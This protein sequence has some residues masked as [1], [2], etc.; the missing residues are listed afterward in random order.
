VLLIS[1]GVR[2]T[3]ALL[4]LSAYGA[5]ALEGLEP[6]FPLPLTTIVLT[7]PEVRKGKKD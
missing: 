1:I 3:V 7:R 2:F 4:L 5:V 6:A